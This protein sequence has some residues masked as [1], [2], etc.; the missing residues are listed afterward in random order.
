MVQ[1][2]L[3]KGSFVTNIDLLYMRGDEC[4]VTGYCDRLVSI[5]VGK[6]GLAIEKQ[7]FEFGG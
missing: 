5:K 1:I 2:W 4:R 6:V 3:T 7:S